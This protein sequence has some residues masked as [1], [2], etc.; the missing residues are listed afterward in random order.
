MLVMVSMVE[1]VVVIVSLPL[2]YVLVSI[3]GDV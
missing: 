2:V 3:A 1:N